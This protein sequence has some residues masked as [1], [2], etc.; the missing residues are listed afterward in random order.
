MRLI[1]VDQY[2]EPGL[3][4]QVPILDATGR[5]TALVTSYARDRVPP[6]SVVTRATAG[7]CGVLNIIGSTAI[8][9]L[10]LRQRFFD[11]MVDLFGGNDEIPFELGPVSVSSGG[12]RVLD[13]AANDPTASAY[14]TVV[15]GPGLAFRIS[16][17]YSTDRSRWV[18]TWGHIPRT[19]STVGYGGEHSS[20]ELDEQRDSHALPNPMLNLLWVVQEGGSKQATYKGDVPKY[21]QVLE[22][23]EG[24][25][26]GHSG[27]LILG[28]GGVSA[29]EVA[30]TLAHGIPLLGMLGTS[31]VADYLPLLLAHKLEPVPEG[32]I[33]DAFRQI[34]DAGLDAATTDWGMPL[35]TLTGSPLE[36]H[37]WLE[38]M[39]MGQRQYS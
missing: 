25:G 23:F 16:Q 14:I 29:Y 12:S 31:R 3:R 38:Y 21:T 27:N 2:F 28:G 22:I 1:S 36:G 26:E 19:A 18:R 4:S 7:R 10:I 17:R 30:Y 39:G 33:R 5:N 34:I 6:G 37:Q 20:F 13:G 11:L 24:T 9:D 35:I 8:D 32:A 15:E